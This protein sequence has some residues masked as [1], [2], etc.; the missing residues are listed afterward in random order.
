MNESSESMEEM[1]GQPTQA[2]V[3]EVEC[4][5]TR[6]PAV[7]WFIFAA[8]M[9]GFATWCFIDRHK[10]PRPEAWDMKHLNE[11][12][13]YILNNWGP[14]V[15][16]PVGL[17]SLWMG[18]RKLTHK[19]IADQQGIGYGSKRIPWDRINRLDP[20]QLQSKGI[21]YLEHGDGQRLTLDSWKLQNFRQLVAFVEQ[22]VP[23]GTRES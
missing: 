13:A 9:I 17:I 1:Q 21:L 14:A 2:E 20:S 10:H 11:A 6:D 16:L 8:L 18:I 19:L 12:A 5:P 15:F 4:R 23:K 22:K 7:R 3:T